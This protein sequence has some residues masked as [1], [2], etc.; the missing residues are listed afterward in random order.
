MKFDIALDSFRG[1]HHQAYIPIRPITILVGENSSGKTSLL[2]S[3]KYFHDL[4]S[5]KIDPSFNDEPFQLGTFEQIAHHRGRSAGRTDQICVRIRTD[6][7]KSVREKEDEIFP[8]GQKNGF[9]S[10]SV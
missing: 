4:L 5:G 2:A 3:I 6:L 10:F 1:F 9:F 8:D 7:P